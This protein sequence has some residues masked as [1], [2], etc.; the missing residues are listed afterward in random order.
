MSFG[1]S[2]QGRPI[3]VAKRCGADPRVDV[4]VIGVIH[5]NEV[6]GVPVISR[7]ARSV[8]SAGQ[9]LWLL[10]SVNPDGHRRAIRQNARGV[11]LNR[12][13]PFDWRGGGSAFDTYFPGRARA[14]EPETRAALAMIRAIRPDVTIWY[15]QHLAMTIRPPLPWRQALA[16]RYA[17]VS[18]LP[19]RSYPGARLHGTASSWQHAEQPQ[20]LA[21]VVE[22]PAGALG[23]SAVRRHV[24]AVRAVG[25]AA[26]ADRVG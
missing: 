25:A 14:S 10:A 23:A 24:A 8:P 20:S 22:L 9:C 6:A 16:E 13:F 4:L 15:H 17:S 26:S 21:L 11:D 18:R 2:S 12:N 3:R 5:G 1:Q 19:V 7:L